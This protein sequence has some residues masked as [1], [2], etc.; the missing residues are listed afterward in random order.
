VWR[1]GYSVALVERKH[2]EH[3]KLTERLPHG[4]WHYRWETARWRLRHLWSGLK[5]H[6]FKCWQAALD[7]AMVGGY[8]ACQAALARRAA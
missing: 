6:R 8:D 3:P 7:A 4:A 5:E 1:T 2:P